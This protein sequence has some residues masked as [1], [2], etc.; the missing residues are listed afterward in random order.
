MYQLTGYRQSYTYWP[1]GRDV[2]VSDRLVLCIDHSYMESDT[3]L[4]KKSCVSF[5][6]SRASIHKSYDFY[7]WTGARMSGNVYGS[8][9][10]TDTYTKEDHAAGVI[11]RM[12][13]LALQGACGDWQP[14][15]A[16]LIAALVGLIS[17][18][19][20]SAG[21][22][23]QSLTK[24]WGQLPAIPMYSVKNQ[25]KILKKRFTAKGGAFCKPRPVPACSNA[26]CYCLCGL[27]GLPVQKSPWR[28]QYAYICFT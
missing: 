20:R 7:G 12:Q 14:I 15:D 16:R 13:P 17:D 21:R 9:K 19:R 22:S 11:Q 10:K 28:L 24:E 25:K 2:S 26:G 18:R 6:G 1:S 5:P 27:P 4:F 8:R 23:G 3:Q